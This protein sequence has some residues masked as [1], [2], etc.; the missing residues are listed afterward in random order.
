MTST[1]NDTLRTFSQAFALAVILAGAV[2]LAAQSTATKPPELVAVKIT[3][4][5]G[6]DG[7]GDDPAWRNPVR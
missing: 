5:P 3:Q 4:P 7:R 6:L 1:P 2:G